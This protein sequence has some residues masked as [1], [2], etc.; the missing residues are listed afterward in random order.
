MAN[1]DSKP[2]SSPLAELVNF[3]HNNFLWLLLACYLLAAVLP[4]P[5]LAIRGLS[6]NSNSEVTAPM[7]LLAL[8]LFCAS[9]VVRWSQVRDLMQRPGILLLGLIAIWIVPGLFVSAL[10][11]ILPGLLGQTVTTGML[12]GLAIVAAMPAA[13]SSVGWSQNAHGNVA[14]SLGLI[15]ITIVL[16]P[17]ATPQMLN[18]MGLSLSSAETEQCKRMVTE[19]SGGFF[20]VWVIL[21][22]LAG[23]LV[24]KLAGP[25]RVER[26]SG[27]L[28]IVSAGTLLLLN[29]ANASLAL[30]RVLDDESATL[31]LLSS[32][33]A[34][35]LSL[36]GFVSAWMLSQVMKLDRAS[37]VSLIF[38]FSMKHT[39]LGLVLAG[40]VLHEE[41]R[42]ILIIILAT[43]LQHV[44]AGGF[45]WFLARRTHPVCHEPG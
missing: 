6:L 39:G 40:E 28:R 23:A 44:A 21:P 24:N 1:A 4:G 25:E 12:V 22:A 37:W 38:G 36:L 16:C 42:V 34:I 45:G 9:A 26:F 14:L 43:M 7:L 17:I 13:N 41:P 19:F 30:P 27:L 33:L 3:V 2:R 8:L 32:A 18:L 31:L 35:M 10:G 11:W 15:V 5:G 20:I 29:Y